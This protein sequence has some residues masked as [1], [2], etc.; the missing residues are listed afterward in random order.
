MSPNSTSNTMLMS[1]ALVIGS[2]AERREVYITNTARRDTA[3]RH[4]ATEPPSH[5]ASHH[6]PTHLLYHNT[7]MIRELRFPQKLIPV[8]YFSWFEILS[9]EGRGDEKLCDCIISSSSAV[10]GGHRQTQAV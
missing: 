5:R 6:S 9:V 4:R 2:A 8:Y 1:V 7:G 10:R 3:E